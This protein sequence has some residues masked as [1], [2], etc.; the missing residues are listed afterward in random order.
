MTKYNGKYDNYNFKINWDSD[1]LYDPKN[2]ALDVS[3][4][5]KDG[6]EYHAN[7]TT[8]NFIDHMFEKNKRTGECANGTYFCMPDMI[9]IEEINDKNIKATID[10]LIKNLAVDEF[11]KELHD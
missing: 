9:I 6:Q 3:L 7:F 4:F 5:T 2:E 8:K 1:E 10:D 11:F